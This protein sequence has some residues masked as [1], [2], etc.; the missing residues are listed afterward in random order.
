MGTHL[1]GTHPSG[2]SPFEALQ[3]PPTRTGPPPDLKK[4]KC[5][6]GLTWFW[7]PKMV[8]PKVVKHDSQT[9]FWPKLVTPS[10]SMTARQNRATPEQPCQPGAGSER[11]R[12]ACLRLFN[13]AQE[14]L[15]FRR[16]PTSR[17]ASQKPRVG[18]S[19][20]DPST[21]GV[22]GRAPDPSTST[23]PSWGVPSLFNDSCPRQ[24]GFHGT[25][26]THRR[27]QDDRRVA[28][29]LWPTLANP[30]LAQ[31]RG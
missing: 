21:R 3:A 7:P 16:P 23:L 14:T 9:S 27:V 6:V 13:L 22:V 2:P 8:W 25:K 31:F 20:D 19:P 29:G 26:E 15:S 28:R 10:T 5:G 18:L 17:L 1:S 4:P 12:V 11:W 30:I 24:I